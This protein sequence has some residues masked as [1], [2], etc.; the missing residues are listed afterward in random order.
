MRRILGVT[1]WVAVAALLCGNC[2][3]VGGCAGP[4][5][6]PSAEPS[7]TGE[8]EYVAKFS[9]DSPITNVK[10]VA[11]YRFAQDVWDRTDGKVRID[12]YPS[13]QLFSEIDSIPAIDQNLIQF[14]YVNLTLLGGMVKGIEVGQLPTFFDVSF[15]EHARILTSGEYGQYLTEKIE[16]KMRV[17]VAGFLLLGGLNW[18]NNVRPIKKPADFQGI[19]MRV[20][21]GE[22]QIARM[23]ALGASPVQIPWDEC[24]AALQQG[25]VDGIETTIATGL[26]AAK[27]WDVVE[28]V[29]VSEHNVVETTVLV[30]SDWWDKLPATYQETIQDTAHEV[31]AW[32]RGEM[33]QLEQEGI[34]TMEDHG[35]VVYIP[36]PEE[37]AAFRTKIAPIE[38]ELVEKAGLDQQLIEAAKRDL[39]R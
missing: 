19:K 9:S 18:G 29:T 11:A 32:Q 6:G 5:G 34:E 38:D 26:V 27:M 16:N 14:A 31:W 4:T 39:G 25:V 15:E 8:V 24:Y 28:Y 22:P 33:E 35:M 37:L 17:K 23:K 30:N 1:V 20:I 36:T 7:Q 10:T 3:A 2:L 21:G 13:A 12:V